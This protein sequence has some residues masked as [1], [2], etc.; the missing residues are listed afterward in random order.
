MSRLTLTYQSIA[1]LQPPS[2]VLVRDRLSRNRGLWLF[3]DGS[4]SAVVCMLVLASVQ[5]SHD[6]LC[7]QW[8]QLFWFI[9]S[10]HSSIHVRMPHWQCRIASTSEDACLP[11]ANQID[12]Y[13]PGE[14]WYLDNDDDGNRCGLTNAQYAL[15][16]Q[17]KATGLIVSMYCKSHLASVVRDLIEELV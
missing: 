2:L 10:S 8:S 12:N 11:K 17:D 5:G 14:C 6:S 16:V 1:R 4:N 15:I 3:L 7:L 9:A 13:L